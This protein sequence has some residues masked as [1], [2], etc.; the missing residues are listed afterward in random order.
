MYNE[1][2]GKC[3]FLDVKQGKQNMFQ[4]YQYVERKPG[5]KKLCTMRSLLLIQFSKNAWF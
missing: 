4:T 2:K 3:L 5:L 1:M